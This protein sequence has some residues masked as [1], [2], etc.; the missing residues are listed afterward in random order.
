LTK[1]MIHFWLYTEK[2]GRDY[3][4]DPLVFAVLYLAHHPLFWGTIIWIIARLRLKQPVV[5][6]SIIA[7]FFYTMPY[8][9]V[10]IF[11]RGLPWWVYVIVGS[12]IIIGGR[13]AYRH[14]KSKIAKESGTT[15]T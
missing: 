9:Y 2:L 14:A 12:V 1:L 6:H 8:A 15:D 7:A 5:P 13:H 11:G 10:L 3:H 4:V